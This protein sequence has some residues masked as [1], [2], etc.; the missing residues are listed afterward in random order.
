[1]SAIRWRLRAQVLV[2]SGSPTRGA[3]PRASSAFAER[4]SSML[5]RKTF[6]ASLAAAGI[7][8]IAGC[9]A[10]R[11]TEKPRG[12]PRPAPPPAAAG[13]PANTATPVSPAAEARTEADAAAQ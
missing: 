13:A 8:F 11:A 9:A 12:D 4:I 2:H 5:F 10:E 1:M 6:I 7:G 3:I